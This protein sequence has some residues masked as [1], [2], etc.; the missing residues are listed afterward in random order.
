M[1]DNVERDNSPHV[2]HG[3]KVYD[4]KEARPELAALLASVVYKMCNSPIHIIHL[5]PSS[6]H[7]C[8]NEAQWFWA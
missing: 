1:G 5:L 6:I 3:T 4:A 2:L 7:I 8:M